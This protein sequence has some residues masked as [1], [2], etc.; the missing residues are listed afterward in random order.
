MG[1]VI[2]DSDPSAVMKV[3]ARCGFAQGAVVLARMP[4]WGRPMSADS[5]ARH[6]TGVVFFV[7]AT[8]A[9]V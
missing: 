1:C 9:Q 2:Y 5:S 3:E 6:A 4:R 7:H 8:T